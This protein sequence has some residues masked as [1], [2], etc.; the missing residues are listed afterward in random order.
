MTDIEAKP[1]IEAPEE[2]SD[3]M[4]IGVEAK[5]EFAGSLA[6]LQRCVSVKV[7]YVGSTAESI[8]LEWAPA[9]KKARR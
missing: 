3:S 1:E 7:G 5:L 9:A 6:P 8:E 4:T 2:L